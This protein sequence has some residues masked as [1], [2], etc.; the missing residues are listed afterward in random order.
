MNRPHRPDPGASSA[1]TYPVGFDLKSYL[2]AKS[3]K[4]NNALRA[5]LDA[6]AVPGRLLEAM[7]HSLLAGGKRL[8]PVLCLAAAE[9]AGKAD[10]VAMPAACA[11]EMIHTYS[12]IHDDL[13]AMDDDDLRRGIPTCH[14]AFDEATAILAGDG[15]LT[16]AFEILAGSALHEPEK[17]NEWVQVI[18]LVSMAAGAAGMIEG[19]M[20]DMQA[21]GTPLSV[22]ALATLHQLKTGAVIEAAVH[23]G[24]LLGGA[25]NRQLNDLRRYARRIGLAFQVVDDILNVEGDPV[26]MGKS[27]GTDREKRKSTYP[28]VLG[29]SASRNF[30]QQLVGEALKAI[31]DFDNR[32]DPLRAIAVYIVRRNR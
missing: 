24:A 12:L 14:R 27:V 2:K 30:A 19:Q 7:R 18:H 6:V 1:S 9:S 29:V 3:E 32:S 17:R 26:R 28:E 4:V 20:Q 16:G 11:L 23:C 8:R 21:E 13:P 15:L 5:Q 25:G 31:Q 10:E 22:D